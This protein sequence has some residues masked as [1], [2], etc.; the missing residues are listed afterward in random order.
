MAATK[1][2]NGRIAVDTFAG[3]NILFLPETFSSEDNSKGPKDRRLV[4]EAARASRI[5]LELD[6]ECYNVDE[7][8]TPIDGARK[9]VLSTMHGLEIDLIKE[10]AESQKVML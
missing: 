3:K 9:K 10:L 5:P 4:K 1:I 7:H 8:E 2:G 6:V